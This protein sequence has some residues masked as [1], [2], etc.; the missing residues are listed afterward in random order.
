MDQTKPILGWKKIAIPFTVYPRHCI[1]LYPTE[2]LFMVIYNDFTFCLEVS[3]HFQFPF[4][5]LS[6]PIEWVENFL[7]LLTNNISCDR[8]NIMNCFDT[9]SVTV[10]FSGV[11]VTAKMYWMLHI[12]G[13]LV[14]LPL[15]HCL[16]IRV[17]VVHLVLSNK[18]VQLFTKAST[19]FH[20][21]TC[22]QCV[23]VWEC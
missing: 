12:N 7:Y 6:S 18:L 11:R 17:F 16:L 5:E 14:P 19:T 4:L 23:V 2:M 8:K 10:S 3:F 20:L 13:F 9:I 1:L 15:W 22:N 21:H